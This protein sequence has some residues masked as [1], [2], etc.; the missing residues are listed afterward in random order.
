MAA[1]VPQVHFGTTQGSF[2][3]MGDDG[4]ENVHKTF[5]KKAKPFINA[6]MLLVHSQYRA[7]ITQK[8]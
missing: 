7:L 6:E 5:T 3:S 2:M 1:P 4:G 8:C